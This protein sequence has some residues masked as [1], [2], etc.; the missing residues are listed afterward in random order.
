M[1]ATKYKYVSGSEAYAMGKLP[2]KSQILQLNDKGR[3]EWTD[4][5][6]VN[7]PVAGDVPESFNLDTVVFRIPVPNVEPMDVLV[8]ENNAYLVVQQRDCLRAIGLGKPSKA[9]LDVR[10]N[11]HDGK[12][13][14]G[15]EEVIQIRSC[16]R[17]IKDVLDVDCL[18][19]KW[20]KDHSDRTDLKK[21]VTVGKYTA[22]VEDGKF[23]VDEHGASGTLED[24]ERALE[25]IGTPI[26]IKEGDILELKGKSK[27]AF[28][29]FAPGTIGHYSNRL[30]AIYCNVD[31][32]G[33]CAGSGG[34]DV[35][36]NGKLDSK[37]STVVNIYRGD[38]T[39][40]WFIGNYQDSP[41]TFKK[42]E[43]AMPDFC[44]FDVKVVEGGISVGCQT[45]TKAQLEELAAALKESKNGSE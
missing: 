41:E 32:H 16:K 8:T 36:E 39:F 22:I 42:A 37:T 11:V 35:V 31:E 13:Y 19:E 5:S 26:E 3:R 7:G 10:I 24:V 29:Q 2:E 23:K 6:I 4:D 33:K 18:S 1:K 38:H 14:A 20:L 28:V 43:V 25:A 9:I 12:I 30:I 44:G 17:G 34:W 21:E 40:F 15:V 27:W 45:I